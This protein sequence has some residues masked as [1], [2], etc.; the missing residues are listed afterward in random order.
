MPQYNE[1][2]NI[3]TSNV[4]INDIVN[5]WC[6]LSWHL[7]ICYVNYRIY[8]YIKYTLNDFVIHRTCVVICSWF[9][10]YWWRKGSMKYFYGIQIR[11]TFYSTYLSSL[12]FHRAVLSHRH[13]R[14]Y[15]KAY[16]LFW[17]YENVWLRFFRSMQIDI[18]KNFYGFWQFIL[19]M[20]WI[21]WIFF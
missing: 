15:T 18:K 14:H 7:T 6:P 2:L 20:F 21:K 12:L 8:N 1:Y 9:L 11:H 10:F 17:A 5:E 16:E 13:Y 3:I 4:I 19:Y